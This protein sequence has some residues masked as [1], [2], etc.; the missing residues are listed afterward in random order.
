M[1]KSRDM[2][3]ISPSWV[4]PERSWVCS[5]TLSACLFLGIRELD[6][7]PLS[8]VTARES[9]MNNVLELL[10]L[11]LSGFYRSAIMERRTTQHHPGCT[12]EHV[13]P[14][15]PPS[16]ALLPSAKQLACVREVLNQ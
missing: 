1:E 11:K 8:E 7:Q 12:P 16:S 3:A 6:E 2:G 10:P 14:D 15:N 5:T 9:Q 4:A 13:G